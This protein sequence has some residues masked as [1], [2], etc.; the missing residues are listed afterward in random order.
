MSS[1]S[2]FLAVVSLVVM[3]SW[4]PSARAQRGLG[5]SVPGDDDSPRP[6]REV[7]GLEEV[8][9]D[10]QLDEQLP[11]DLTFTDHTGTQVRLGDYFEGDRPVL[12]TFNYYTCPVVCSMILEATAN[13]VA[14][15]PWTAGDEYEIVTISID[16]R[17]TPELAAKKREE[18]LRKYGRAR[19]GVDPVEMAKAEGRWH[20]LVGDPDNIEAAADA[21][22]VRYFY[23]EAQEQYAHP[24]VITLLTPD[25]K[26]ARYL[27]GLQFNPQD[28][29]LALLEASKGR[30]ISTTEKVI[31]YCYRYDAEAS[32]YVLFGWRVMQIGAGLL[33]TIFGVILFVLWR[34]EVR[35]R[36]QELAGGASHHPA[37]THA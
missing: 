11:L 31:L 4:A 9:V 2:R 13:T 37:S 33:A 25:G 6:V 12:L 22:G 29:R 26:F 24:A 20:F 21:A 30:S 16:P 8:D 14:E 15:M 23:N 7:P 27:Y 36:R 5:S 3:A 1:F 32:S 35:K 17:D 28:V 19:D 10:E 18:I 34:R